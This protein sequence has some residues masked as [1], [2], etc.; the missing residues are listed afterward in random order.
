MN[1]TFL[2]LL[3]CLAS[4]TQ[5][6]TGD[7]KLEISFKAVTGATFDGG[8]LVEVVNGS[9]GESKVIELSQPYSV[10][11]PFGVWSIHFVGFDEP[12]WQAPHYC[13]GVDKIDFNVN[14]QAVKIQVNQV[15]CD[16][17]PYLT[18]KNSKSIGAMWDVA[19]WDQ[20]AWKQSQFQ[21]TLLTEKCVETTYLNENRVTHEALSDKAAQKTVGYFMT[22][23]LPV[24]PLES[25]KHDLLTS[26]ERPKALKIPQNH[27]EPTWKRNLAK[28]VKQK[29]IGEV[30]RAKGSRY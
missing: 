27:F 18:L 28:T 13:G 21:Q 14:D 30:S 7:A 1:K 25:S 23:K 22:Q 11:L 12:N 3:V 17:E 26:E 16:I 2:F 29:K 8:A 6:N 9:T 4:C 24:Q 5:K 10:T 20:A 15:N 19:V